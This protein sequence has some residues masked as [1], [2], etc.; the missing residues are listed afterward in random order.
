MQLS[1][2]LQFVITT[3]IPKMKLSQ[4]NWT[5]RSLNSLLYAAT[6]SDTATHQNV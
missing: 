2:I 4:H 6:L 3:S 1:W 5:N